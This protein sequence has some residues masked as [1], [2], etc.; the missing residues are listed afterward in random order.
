VNKNGEGH[1]KVSRLSISTRH[2]II[3]YSKKG[4]TAKFEGMQWKTNERYTQTK[5]TKNAKDTKYL[6]TKT[7]QNLYERK[8]I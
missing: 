7:I 1:I 3:E 6:L 5:R 4:L 8:D 2:L